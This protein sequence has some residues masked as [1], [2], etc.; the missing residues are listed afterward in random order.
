MLYVWAICMRGAV[1]EVV[2][3]KPDAVVIKQKKNRWFLCKAA[4]LLLA[5]T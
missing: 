1:V 4:A 5:R 2:I 3:V